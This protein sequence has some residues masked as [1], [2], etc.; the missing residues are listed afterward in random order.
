M[1]LFWH[2]MA[3]ICRTIIW[4]KNDMLLLALLQST[5]RAGLETTWAYCQMKKFEK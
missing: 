4:Q 3:D 2:I 1:T 5:L